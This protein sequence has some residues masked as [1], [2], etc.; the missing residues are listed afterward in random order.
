M[1]RLLLLSLFVAVLFPG[2]PAA[3]P[4]FRDSLPNGLIVLTYEDHRLPV[5]DIRL[6]CRSGAAHDPAAKSGLASLATAMLVR[7]SETMSGDSV[8]AILEFLGARYHT[9]A[10]Y[11]ISHI[12]VKVL[13]EYLDQVLDLLADG[14]RKPGFDPGEFDPEYAVALASARRMFDN[15]R[16]VARLEF[17]RL[18]FEGHPYAC[19]PWGDTTGLNN[20]TLKDAREF[21]RTHYVPNNCFILIVGDINRKDALEKVRA[22]FGDWQPGTVP[23]LELPELVQP[24]GLHVKLITRPDLNQSYINFGHPG[25]SITHPQMLS[26]R[27]MAF[28]LGG[29]ALA[30]RMGQS[31]REESGLAYD[32]RC[33][34]DRRALAGA[35]RATVQT[36][37]PKAA[38]EKMLTEI[39]LMHKQGPAE[40]ELA[41]AQNY[42]TG[43]FPLSYSSSR[44]K[45]GHVTDAEVYGL[46]TDWLDVFPDRIRALTL[47]DLV[48]AA[49]DRLHPEGFIMV[50]VGNVTKE[51]LDLPDAVWIE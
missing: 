47:P 2:Q 24:D 28:A 18:L 38:I 27:L 43:S 31:V 36:S 44:G 35:Y 26:T 39:R 21:H 6:V 48:Q 8:A 45:L 40:K 42:Y 30:S 49:H 4:L 34:F 3:V 37:S 5:T 9:S 15:P 23:A 29:S 7:G 46:G 17:N 33:W 12:D 10:D 22:R 11:D 19:L 25:I 41:T 20:I 13:S 51:D 50:I 16:L 14:I 1:T 32:V